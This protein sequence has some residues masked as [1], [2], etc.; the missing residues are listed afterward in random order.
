[1]AAGKVTGEEICQGLG[2]V[3]DYIE[4]LEGI[5]KFLLGNE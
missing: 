5:G 4:E 1:M 2:V 3:D